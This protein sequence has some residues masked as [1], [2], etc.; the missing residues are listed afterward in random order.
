MAL[1]LVSST[2]WTY[3]KEAWQ[4]KA[5][6]KLSATQGHDQD[7]INSCQNKHSSKSINLYKQ[8]IGPEQVTDRLS[9]DF[10]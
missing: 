5:Q 2:W 7:V 1:V 4:T 10:H 3:F 8:K 9:L 6:V